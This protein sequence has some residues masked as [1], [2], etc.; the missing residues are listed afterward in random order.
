MGV[1]A[2]YGCHGWAP[3]PSD[4]RG[5]CTQLRRS[6]PRAQAPAAWGPCLLSREGTRPPVPVAGCP[7]QPPTGCP[8]KRTRHPHRFSYG[9]GT[10]CPPCRLPCLQPCRATPQPLPA[11]R[12][13]T[14]YL[15]GVHPPTGSPWGLGGTHAPTGSPSGGPTTLPASHPLTGCPGRVYPPPVLA[16]G[17]SWRV[18]PHTSGRLP[19]GR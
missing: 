13:P 17:S 7:P 18:A 8:W 1:D 12:S 3:P 19:L 4:E 14:G 15:K 11:P 10:P 9:G 6:P 2:G 16:P 5:G